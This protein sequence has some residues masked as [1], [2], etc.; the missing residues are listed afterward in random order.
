MLT[1]F[2]GNITQQMFYQ[3]WKFE[4]DTLVINYFI[5]KYIFYSMVT[6]R[7]LRW[8]PWRSTTS[9]FVKATLYTIIHFWLGTQK[10]NI[11]SKN[12]FYMKIKFD[13]LLCEIENVLQKRRNKINQV[14][15]IRSKCSVFPTFTQ[16]HVTT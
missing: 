15:I 3:L 13:K 16:H 4:L 5:T 2:V 7:S 11:N 14:S 10:S 12:L 6:R 8:V 9:L 1:D